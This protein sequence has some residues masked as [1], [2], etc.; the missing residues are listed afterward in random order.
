MADQP[1]DLETTGRHIVILSHPG[2]DSFNH[3][4]ARAYCDAVRFYGQEAVVRDLYA[5]GFNPVL[6]GVER[7]GPNHPHPFRDVADELEIIRRSD[8]FVMIYPIW[9][10]SAPAMLKGYVD[11]VLGAGVVP[12]DVQAGKSTSLLGDKRMLS[13]TTSATTGLWLDEQ[14]QQSALRTVFDRY[15]MFA[16]GMHSQKHVHFGHITDELIER[17]ASQHLQDVKE[18]AR[19]ICAEVAVGDEALLHD[20]SLAGALPA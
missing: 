10:G 7:P 14:G 11:R 8:V 19:H 16:F 15:L 20:P 17:S 6:S 1:Q 9:F 13:F 3:A 5:M 18:Q 2:P 12:S 4:I